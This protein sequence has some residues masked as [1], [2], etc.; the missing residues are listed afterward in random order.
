LAIFA[1]QIG[2][3]KI[4]RNAGGRIADDAIRILDTCQIILGVRKIIIMHHTDCALAYTTN[5]EI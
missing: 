2:E 3:A 5:L 4:L 1:L